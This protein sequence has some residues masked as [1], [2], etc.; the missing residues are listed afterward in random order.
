MWNYSSYDKVSPVAGSA[1][2]FESPRPDQLETV[3]E[4]LEAIS[5]GYKYIVLEAGT[6]T[7]KSAIAATL[8][9]ISDSTYILTS[10]KQLQDQYVND[11]ND[12]RA[13]K[14]RSNFR[15]RK[16]ADDGIEHTCDEGRCILEGYSCE[17]SLK[18]QPKP[19]KDNMCHYFY[20]KFL[21]MN[22]RTVIANY[23]YLF[24]E[25]NYVRDF[26]K[27][28]LLICDEAHNLE[29]VLMNQLKLEFS[30]SDL[31]E[32]IHYDL[33][34]DE[35]YD[36]INGEYSDWI[37]FIG[38][39]KEEYLRE[40]DKLES[41]DKPGLREKISFIKNQITDCS[42]SIGHITE[43][44]TTW[45]VD[46]DEEFET[47]K[48]KPLK[49]DNYAKRTLFDYCDVCIFMSA[50]ILDWKL[51]AHW[52]GISADEIYAIRRKSPFQISNNR[53]IPS[54]KYNLS[55]SSIR[56]NAPRTVELIEDI[57]KRHENEKGIIHT[58]SAKCM[59]FL[60]DN[61]DSDR[62]IG[63]ETSNRAEQLER[64]KNS[65]EP[66]VLISP[67][68]DEGVDL[69]GD[70]C[71]FQIIY[72]IPYPDLGDRQV[73]S[74]MQLDSH[75]YDYKTSLRLVQTHGRGMRYA[76]DYCTTYFIDSR[77]KNYVFTNRFLPD[78]FR[79]AIMT[80]YDP[81]LKESLIEKGDSLME[82]EDYESAIRFF[83]ELVNN[84]LFLMD[85][86]PYLKLSQA[87]HEAELFEDELNT[88]LK[89]ISLDMPCSEMDHFKNSLKRLS[90]MGYC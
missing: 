56:V 18:N 53:I 16:Y 72:K 22:S 57:L 63:H 26:Q 66:L 32:Y 13:V 55:R 20:Q 74:R 76:D 70:L 9:N 77:F 10:T 59:E 68:M 80:G 46:W 29:Q 2:P 7:G 39:V 43:D 15:C 84:E 17:Y 81:K 38:F 41:L 50:T 87:Y 14:G 64:F 65:T 75:W 89:F 60:I 54:S 69:P 40:L 62:L 48:F 23:P 71:R 73:F 27:R 49:V 4:I 8:A 45:I 88:I 34:Y 5:K 83:N 6:G 12:F 79:K 36:L 30:R 61:I 21:A 25:L 85:S 11:F 37:D 82:S 67:S 52:L 24:L 90:E 3:S 42:R 78:T 33:I 31:K 19:T 35:V 28:D 44:P 58:V 86:Y 1:F 51:F 47:L